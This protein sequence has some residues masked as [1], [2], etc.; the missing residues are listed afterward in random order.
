[1]LFVPRHRRSQ[2]AALPY[3]CR[4]AAAQGPS[5][6]MSFGALCA[7]DRCRKVSI[8]ALPCR[9]P[10]GARRREFDAA[11][12]CTRGS[13]DAGNS[14][15]VDYF[16]PSKRTVVEANDAEEISANG[17]SRISLLLM[18]QIREI[19]DVDVFSCRAFDPERCC[20]NPRLMSKQIMED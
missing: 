18:P 19:A 17:K 13:D 6:S 12:T 11:F 10:A 20:K 16:L 1:M 5:A 3:G 7:P 15:R 4:L 8:A 14:S 2:I 9:G